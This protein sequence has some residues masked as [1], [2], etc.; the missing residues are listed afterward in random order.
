MIGAIAA[1]DGDG[2]HLAGDLV[3]AG[4]AGEDVDETDLTVSTAQ[5]AAAAYE[6]ISNFIANSIAVLSEHPDVWGTLANDP[7]AV[8]TTVEELLRYAGPMNYVPL[9]ARE[10]IASDECVVKRGTTV[11][12]CLP[13]ANHDREQFPDA[14]RLEPKRRPNHHVSFGMGRFACIGAAF[15]RAQAALAILGL[16]ARFEVPALVH[17]QIETKKS[18]LFYGPKRLPALLRRR[19]LTVHE[20][21]AAR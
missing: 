5:F 1:D 6:N 8:S 18:Q 3:R 10:E 4:R 16:S 11:L 7:S 2:D 15:A 17:D 12:A 9:V 21:D 14:N 19:E 13:L 20:K